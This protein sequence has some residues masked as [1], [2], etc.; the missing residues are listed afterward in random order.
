MIIMG[1]EEGSRDPEHL[2]MG[3]GDEREGGGGGAG[4]GGGGGGGGK[5]GGGPLWF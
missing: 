2:R 4:G 1:S 3:S 5:G